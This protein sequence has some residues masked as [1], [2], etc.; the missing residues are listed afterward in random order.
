[1]NPGRCLAVAVLALALPAAGAAQ[2]AR[3][4]LS[5]NPVPLNGQFVLNV[6]ISGTR[7]ADPALPDLS[8]FAAYLGSGTSTSVQIVNGRMSTTVTIPVSVP[9][10]PGGHV[11]DRSGDGA[12][13][14]PEPPHRRADHRGLQ[15]PG[16]R[17]RRGPHRRWRHRPRRSVRHRDPE[18]RAGLRQPAGRRRVPHLHPRR[19]RRLHRRPAAGHRRLLGRGAGHP[20]RAGGTGRPRRRAVRQQRHPAGRPVSDRRRFQAARS[21]G[22]RG[23]GARA[24]FPPPRPVRRPLR[25]VLRRQPVRAPD[26]GLGRVERPRPRRASGAARR[27]RVV[28]RVRRVARGLGQ[29]GPHRRGYQ[30]RPDAASRHQRHR[31]HP[32]PARAEPEPARGLRG[33]PPRDARGGGADRRR[34]PRQP[35]LRVRHR[36][37]RAGPHDDSPGRARVLRRRPRRVRGGVLRPDYPDRRRRSGP[38]AHPARRARPHRGGSSSAR[39]SASSASPPPPSRS[40]GVRSSA[41]PASGRSPCCP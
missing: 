22:A 27:A 30:R 23:A 32:D 21:A 15:R 29:R 25:R 19:R 10:D 31:Q 35:G 40:S 12:G 20:A 8:A 13:R 16:G 24:A 17:G 3:A 2:S 7:D 28:L 37:A 39:T 26:A 4:F 5:Q 38:R 41:R 11:R 6:E 34:R 33:L 18:R 14:R 9:G 1:M 36:A